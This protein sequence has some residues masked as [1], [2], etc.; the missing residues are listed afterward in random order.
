LSIA[1]TGFAL[2]RGTNDVSKTPPAGL[3]AKDAANAARVFAAGLPAASITRF[4]VLTPALSDLS[5]ISAGP[6]A[7]GVVDRSG[8]LLIADSCAYRPGEAVRVA[9]CAAEARQLFAPLLQTAA[10]RERVARAATSTQPV[11]RSRARRSFVAVPILDTTAS[12]ALVA[13]FAGPLPAPNQ[14]WWS[15]F[16][17]QWTA[18]IPRDAVWLIATTLLFGT[19]VGFLLSHRFVRRLHQLS[20]TA[21]AWGRGDL[22][23][24]AT[25]GKDDELGLLALR[26]NQMADQIRNLLETRAVVAAEEERHRVQRDLHDGIKQELFA[27]SMELAAA[28]ASLHANPD[29]A[30]EALTHAHAA[31]RRAQQELTHL[32]RDEPSPPERDLNLALRELCTR[33]AADTGVEVTYDG[34]DDVRLPML[35]AEALF[36]ITQEALANVRR[37]AAASRVKVRLSTDDG[38]V[39]LEIADDGHGFDTAHASQGMGLVSMRAR[40]ADLE[41]ELSLESGTGGTT[42]RVILPVE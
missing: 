28:K 6:V 35:T 2:A 31:C 27:A 20:A 24:T 38:T 14:S 11:Q 39:R 22:T 32:L 30:A 34:H 4:S 37:H 8:R 10:T 23:A 13:V 18:T 42:I 41:G 17:A 33:T 26:L 12:Y 25:E 36:R 7:V 9:S 3:L 16:W 5:R 29:A 21:A 1:A 19:L 40:V 15:H